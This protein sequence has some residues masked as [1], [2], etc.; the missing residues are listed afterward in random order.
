LSRRCAPFLGQLGILARGWEPVLSLRVLLRT[1][2]QNELYKLKQK[3]LTAYLTEDFEKGDQLRS[4]I[5]KLEDFA[6][7]HGWLK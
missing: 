6:K 1:S 3:M 2:K 4:T 5:A 7:D